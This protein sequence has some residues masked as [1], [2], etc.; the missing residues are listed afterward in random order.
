MAKLGRG[1]SFAEVFFF[2]FSIV[3]ILAGG[4]HPSTENVPVEVKY[5]SYCHLPSTEDL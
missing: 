3:A 4:C 2:F 1:D 5:S